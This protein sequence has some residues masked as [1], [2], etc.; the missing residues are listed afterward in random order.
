MNFQEACKI[1]DVSDPIDEADLKKKFKKL[2]TEYHPDKNKTPGAEKKFKEISEAFEFLKENPTP[3]PSNPFG[4]ATHF[5]NVQDNF[6][7]MDILNGNFSGFGMG[8]SNNR[9]RRINA[10]G[11][12]GVTISLDLSFKESILGCQRDIII[13]R[14]GKCPDCDGAGSLMDCS[15]CNGKG[16]VSVRQGFT[17]FVTSCKCVSSRT[18]KVK[19]CKKCNDGAI[20]E[21]LNLK[22]RIQPGVSNG[23]TLKI[24]D[25]GNFK[26]VNSQE[27]YIGDAFIKL[28]IE[29]KKN[30]KIVGNNL[31][32]DVELSLLEA[33]VGKEVEVETINGT[34]KI[35]VPPKT[36]N[37]DISTLEN[38]GV[39]GFGSH[40][41]NFIV[42]YPDDVDKLINILKN[43]D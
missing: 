34:V 10:R 42:H 26:K 37:K 43:N 22:V 39:G 1:L 9:I 2:A 18:R 16:T 35:I 21:T 32:S 11:E 8:G 3:S 19:V 20:D 27:F 15:I 33:L 25:K 13:K 4:N 41:F 23:Q 38:Y 7:F 40:I 6:D 28:N 24:S 14:K 30:I 12:G 5:Y 29:E 36:K 31:Q 17:T